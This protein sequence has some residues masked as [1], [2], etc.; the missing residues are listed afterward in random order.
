MRENSRVLF[1]GLYSLFYS[2]LVQRVSSLSE[3]DQQLSFLGGFL[4]D[5]Y[6]SF[7]FQNLY[8]ESLGH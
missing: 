2:E 5:L 8:L 6:F 1:L 3:H 4:Q 7:L